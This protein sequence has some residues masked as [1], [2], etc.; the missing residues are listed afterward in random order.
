MLSCLEDTVTVFHFT[1]AITYG[2]SERFAL[3][4]VPSTSAAASAAPSVV[5]RR[6]AASWAG[7]VD[8]PNL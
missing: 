6:S 7:S 8:Q 3:L 2:R 4:P 1:A 5:R